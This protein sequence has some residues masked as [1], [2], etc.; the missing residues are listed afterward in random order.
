MNRAFGTC[1]LLLAGLAWAGE[2]HTLTIYHTNDLQGQ[3]LPGAYF[4]WDKKWF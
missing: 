4:D 3:L 2:T 1:L